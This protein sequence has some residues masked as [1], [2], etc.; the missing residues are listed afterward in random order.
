MMGTL[1]VGALPSRLKRAI[2]I[3]PL[4][5]HFGISGLVDSLGGLKYPKI[6][7]L[8]GSSIATI[9]KFGRLR[10][11]SLFR[12]TIEQEYRNE[13]FLTTFGGETVEIYALEEWQDLSAVP[14]EK[15]KDPALRKFLLKGNR[16]GVRTTVDKR[17]RISLPKWLR[18]KT[19]MEGRIEIKA[20]GNR[21]V[22]K[23]GSVF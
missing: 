8:K 17:G 9:D 4:F 7:M 16:N 23:K 6:G 22:L 3:I 13:V 20:M 12:K 15:L 19:S 1:K 14:E 2:F 11:P 10:I 5:P 21:L 18:D